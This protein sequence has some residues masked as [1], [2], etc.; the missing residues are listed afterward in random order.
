VIGEFDSETGDLN[1]FLFCPSNPFTNFRAR[2]NW[3]ALKGQKKLARGCLAPPH[4][5]RLPR[6]TAPKITSLL[7]ATRRRV[8]GKRE[9]YVPCHTFSVAVL[10]IW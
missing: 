7:P 3:L 4:I 6:V 10:V 9:L 1:V 5:A 8:A 2:A